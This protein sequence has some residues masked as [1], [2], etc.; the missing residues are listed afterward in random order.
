MW[1]SEAADVAGSQNKLGIKNPAIDKLIDRVIFAKDRADLVAATRAL[2]RVLLWNAYL[3][4]Q[5]HVTA[6]RIAYWDMF[7]RPAR[8]PAYEVGFERT[9]WVDR[10]KEA[11]LGPNR[12]K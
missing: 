5:W 10:A 7:G 3:V 6:D 8:L 4:P 12:A 1:S 9:W 11:A 2:D